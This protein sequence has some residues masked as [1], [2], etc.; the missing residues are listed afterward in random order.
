MPHHSAICLRNNI[1][2]IHVKGSLSKW[3]NSM[4]IMELKYDKN[5]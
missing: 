4:Q 3:N 1:F 2:K 5:K